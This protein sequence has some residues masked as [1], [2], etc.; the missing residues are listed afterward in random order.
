MPKCQVTITNN[1]ATKVLRS[2]RSVE[3]TINHAA[4]VSQKRSRSDGRDLRIVSHHFNEQLTVHVETPNSANT[5]IWFSLQADIAAAGGIDSNYWLYFGDLGARDPIGVSIRDK[6]NFSPAANAMRQVGK[7]VAPFHFFD[8]FKYYLNGSQWLPYVNGDPI[9]SDIYDVTGTWQIVNNKAICTVGAG[10]I[11]AHIATK[12]STATSSWR[13][14]TKV[15]VKSGMTLPQMGPA[16]FDDTNSTDNWYAAASNN[17]TALAVIQA[18]SGIQTVLNSNAISTLSDIEV[19]VELRIDNE[20]ATQQVVSAWLSGV[21]IS[22]STVLTPPTTRLDANKA[23]AYVVEDITGTEFELS[24]IRWIS[25]DGIAN[26]DIAITYTIPTLSFSGTWSFPVIVSRDWNVKEI[27]Y[28][29]SLSPRSGLALPWELKAWQLVSKNVDPE[30]FYELRAF[31]DSIKQA[32][33]FQWTSPDSETSEYILVPGSFKVTR[34]KANIYH[35]E[36]QIAEVK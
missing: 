34:E 4:L 7:R 30:E 21:K 2:G 11:D 22:E 1:H 31:F 36:L 9:D 25:W 3:L 5:V 20:S 17:Y 32:E 19:D 24:N 26:A 10:S 8:D 16:L 23:G 35:I 14:I 27:N 15:K 28:P 18:L 6:S 12:N 29:D 33:S 13:L